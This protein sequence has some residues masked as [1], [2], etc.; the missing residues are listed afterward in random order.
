MEPSVPRRI[1][2]VLRLAPLAVSGCGCSPFSNALLRMQAVV[3]ASYF[4]NIDSVPL[5]RALSE[6]LQESKATY[7]KV[8]CSILTP[9]GPVV[10]CTTAEGSVV[11]TTPQAPRSIVVT[12]AVGG[13]THV[14]IGADGAFLNVFVGEE[15]GALSICTVHL[16]NLQV[17]GENKVP[18]PSGIPISKVVTSKK[19]TDVWIV[20]SGVVSICR[21]NKLARET[22]HFALAPDATF[23]EAQVRCVNILSFLP[24]SFAL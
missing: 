23:L 6:L 18:L 10:A 5:N 4:S 20:Q 15:S 9:L 8:W 2:A 16:K 11:L 14:A 19:G 13:V 3:G 21:N 7:E 22:V 24:K 1:L 17:H 12:T